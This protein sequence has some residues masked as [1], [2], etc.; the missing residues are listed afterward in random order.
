LDPGPDKAKPVEYLKVCDVYGAGYFYIPGTDTCLK[1]GG[2]V[3]FDTNQQPGSA[4]NDRID[5]Q[6]EPQTTDPWGT[7][8]N[9]NWLQEY[10]LR[11]G[12]IYELPDSGKPKDTETG[13]SSDGARCI[14]GANGCKLRIAGQDI[15]IN[16]TPATYGTISSIALRTP[17]FEYSGS[18]VD[19]TDFASKIDIDVP[20]GYGATVEDIP[21]IDMRKYVRVQSRCHH[22]LSLL[23][24]QIYMSLMLNGLLEDDFGR[25]KEPAAD[26]GLVFAKVSGRARELPGAKLTLNTKVRAGR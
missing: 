17:T 22:G 25:E 4:I 8:T 18:Y 9:Y 20:P 24:F 12:D 19:V 1:I 7:R 16:K 13:A 26:A 6:I 2:Y 21:A 5:V 14:N 15:G 23:P 11:S 10:R 3:R